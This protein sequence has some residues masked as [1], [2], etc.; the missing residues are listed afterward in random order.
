MITLRLGKLGSSNQALFISGFSPEKKY[1][2]PES[3]YFYF[4]LMIKFKNLLNL[5]YGM[6]LPKFYKQGSYQNEI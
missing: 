2:K 5:G 3:I 6:T 4:N 1:G